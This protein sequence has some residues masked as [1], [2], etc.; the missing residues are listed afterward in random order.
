[1]PKLSACYYFEYV[2][3]KK[4][5]R[6]GRVGKNKQKLKIRRETVALPFSASLGKKK[7]KVTQEFLVNFVAYHSLPC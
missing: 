1:M 3:L 4:R 6:S 5:T 2:S 7:K